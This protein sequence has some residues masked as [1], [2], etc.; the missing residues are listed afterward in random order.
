MATSITNT[1]ISATSLTIGSSGNVITTVDESAANP[2]VGIGTTTPL[3]KL[4]VNG[5]NTSGAEISLTNTSMSTDRKTMNWFMTGDKAHWR[6]LNDAQTAG[7]SSISLDYD[8]YLTTSKGT[9]Q[10]TS[11]NSNTY[12]SANPIN[13]WVEPSST[14]R[15]AITPKYTDSIIYGDFMIPMSPQGAANILMIINPWYSTDG[16]STKTLVT[17]GQNGVSL[18][19]NYAQSWFRSSNGYDLND[20]QNHICKF[21]HQPNTTST[22]TYGFYYRSEGSNTTYFNISAGDSS[23]WGWS[24]SQCLEL[25]E[26][27]P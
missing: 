3:R 17:T 8:G 27:R 11:S 2:R 24:A 18:R 13:A 7:G 9:V 21:R 20:M 16:G 10:T 14:Y 22:V 4:H 19:T 23:T 26:V 5:D 12:V 25:R 15:V 6:L 1:D